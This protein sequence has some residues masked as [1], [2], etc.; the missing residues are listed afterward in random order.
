MRELKVPEDTTILNIAGDDFTPDAD[1]IITVP[2]GH[3]QQ[4]L[5]LGCTDP[6]AAPVIPVMPSVD[7]EAVPALNEALVAENEGLK[8]DL[9][10]AN[11]K[12]TML[13]TANDDL[14]DQVQAM[15]GSAETL[16]KERNEALELAEGYG[17]VIDGLRGSV[18]TAREKLEAAGLDPDEFLPTGTAADAGDEATERPHGDAGAGSGSES[19]G[20]A[21]TGEEDALPRLDEAPDFDGMEY[22]SVLAWIKGRKVAI[23]ANTKKTD[24]IKL[25]KQVFAD[26]KAAQDAADEGK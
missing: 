6:D 2:E 21:G 15:S 22:N 9:E 3:V 5:Q 25:A 12:V 10:E 14:R 20:E 4:A 11:G 18:T 7:A 1:G 24:A 23:P 13:T 19:G 8:A 26:Q 16:T 17:S